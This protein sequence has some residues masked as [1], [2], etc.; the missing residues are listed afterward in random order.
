M[1][2]ERVCRAVNFVLLLF[3]LTRTADR[4]AAKPSAAGA[5]S[6]R[7]AAQPAGSNARLQRGAAGGVPPGILPVR[8]MMARQMR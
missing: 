5:G 2:I 8:I 1:E 3:A 6:S 4:A 7:P